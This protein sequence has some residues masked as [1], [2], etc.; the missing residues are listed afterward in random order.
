MTSIKIKICG[1]REPENIRQVC[2]LNPDY[3]GFIFYPKSKRFVTDKEAKNINACV[4]D[5]VKKVG[6]FVNE[7]IPDIIR[8]INLFG[9]DYIQLHGEEPVEYCSD[10]KS[11]GIR[12]IKSFG[13]DENFDFEMLEPFQDCCD[14]FLFD[15][16]SPAY[17]GTGQKFNWQ[18][19]SEYTLSKPVFLSGGIGANDAEDIK[20]LSAFK[21]YA[22]DLNSKFETG[23]AQKDI[24][25]LENF[26]TEIRKNNI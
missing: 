13:I 5:S 14:Y 15:T 17:G 11:I 21:P 1:M 19:L 8:R 18:K 2:S 9:L 16:K 3:I 4:P 22:L 23:P 26:I 24:K 7:L 25:L 12:I 6:V 20:N 10:I